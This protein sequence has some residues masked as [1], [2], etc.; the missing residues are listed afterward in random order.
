MI[1]EGTETSKK[2]CLGVPTGSVEMNMRT[3]VQ[4]L[5]TLSR[6]RIWHYC[7]LRCRRKT[8]L[9]FG[10]AVAVAQTS[11]CT[12]DSTPS[13]ELPHT[14]GTALRKKQ[15]KNKRV[16]ANIISFLNEETKR[17]IK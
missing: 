13:L 2:F 7:E 9:R 11:I 5:A 10:I 6:L 17:E 1:T 3:Q 8:R 4:S 15:K 16:G 12:S 14:L